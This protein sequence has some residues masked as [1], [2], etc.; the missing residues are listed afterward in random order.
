LQDFEG[1]HVFARSLFV[2]VQLLLVMLVM[3]V[4]RFQTFPK[5]WSGDN[6]GECCPTKPLRGEVT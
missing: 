2:V 3:L 1:I 4:V 5:T 6:S